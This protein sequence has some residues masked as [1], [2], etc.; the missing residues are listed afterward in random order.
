[1]ADS[2]KNIVYNITINDKGK[3]KI[4]NLTK[5]FVNADNAV[6]KLNA[7]L[8][9]Q[10]QV[11]A[12][13]TTK[14]LNPMIDKTGLAGATMVELG[15]TISDANYG[16][17]GIAN[18]LSQL[19]TL[20]VTLIA[21]TGGL[22]NGLAALGKAFMGP[23]GIIVVF[24]IAIALLE[25]FS[26]EQE[27]AKSKTDDL[28]KSI[29]N[30]IRS[31]SQLARAVDKYN[32]GGE[33]LRDT[34]ALL[35]SEF[36][37]FDEAFQDLAD[38]EFRLTIFETDVFGESIKTIYEGEEAI[39]KLTN[40][41]KSLMETEREQILVN[42]KLRR[43]QSG[44]RAKELLAQGDSLTMKTALI[45]TNK[46]EIELLGQLRESERKEIA[47]RKILDDIKRVEGARDISDLEE[48][49][50]LTYDL[51]QAELELEEARVM[52][53][54]QEML[55]DEFVSQF[56]Q[57]SLLER[58]NAE[59]QAAL[60]QLDA[61]EKDIDNFL[62]YQMRKAD[63]QN[64][65]SEERAKYMMKE[66]EAFE[67]MTEGMARLFGEQSAVG[68]AF[69]VA[70][71]TINTYLAA[72]QVLKDE[73]IPTPLKSVVMAGIIAAGLGNVREILKVDETGGGRLKGG[74]VRAANVEAPD[75]NIVGA[76]PQ[77]QLAQSVSS[78]QQKPLRAF[79]V[80]KDIKNA[81][82]FDRNTISG[83][84]TFG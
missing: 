69:A 12:E 60:D 79:V 67:I 65:F 36:K 16:I 56:R 15:R 75:F 37:E 49:I 59:E 83:P 33:A 46:E 47:L 61:Y 32:L 52:D 11:I 31:F 64:Y 6:N 68:K 2:T 77:S 14:G 45:D 24:Q 1:M 9:A 5:S 21:T 18:N 23:L 38:N 57:Q 76:S 82:D 73:L 29:D 63:I 19:S 54:D 70:N 26:M 51:K 71:A 44:E 58:I 81:G 50:K 53:L 17:R 25:R 4:D 20:F 10:Q 55:R 8:R 7:D 84:A 13:T 22:R 41:F 42:E 43:I 66:L 30:Q 3:I 78:Q 28:T 35:S 34:V 62:F 39:I 48:K 72:S 80:Y 27:K 74:G 40:V